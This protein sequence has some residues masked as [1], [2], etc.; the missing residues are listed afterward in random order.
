VLDDLFTYCLADDR[1]L[2][3]TN[4]SNHERDHAWFAQHAESFDATVADVASG[5]AMLAL[6]GPDARAI[7]ARHIEG[8]APSRM[9][10]P[11]ARA[12]GADCLICGTGYTGE[13][14]VELLLAP[15]DAPQVW[16]ALTANGARPAGLGARDT[17]RLRVC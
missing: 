7:L 8:E 9:R 11:R 17:R 1:Y 13:D 16:D 15:E 12:A 10:T 14:G 6:Q 4:A 2:T 3:V 5:H